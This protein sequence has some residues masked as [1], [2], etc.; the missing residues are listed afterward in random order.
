[1]QYT[2]ENGANT[3]QNILNFEVKD[4]NNC[5][6]KNP[7]TKAKQMPGHTKTKINLSS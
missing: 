2:S 5:T 6:E 1:M 4:K 3:K 7:L